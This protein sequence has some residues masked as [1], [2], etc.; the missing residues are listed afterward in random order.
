MSQKDPRFFP[1]NEKGEDSKT[2]SYAKLALWSYDGGDDAVGGFEFV[3]AAVMVS[4]GI[5]N[6]T[7]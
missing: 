7:V 2:V 1:R 3:D 4:G 5:T 6:L